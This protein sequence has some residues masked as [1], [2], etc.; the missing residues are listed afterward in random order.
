[1]LNT[2][3]CQQPICVPNMAAPFKT[4]FLVSNIR[5][6]NFSMAPRSEKLHDIS[7]VQRSQL[8]L[9]AQRFLCPSHVLHTPCPILWPT[10]M[11]HTVQATKNKW[12]NRTYISSDV[13]SLCDN[14]QCW[15]GWKQRSVVGQPI[16]SHHPHVWSGCSLAFIYCE[17]TSER[18]GFTD[19]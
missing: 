19:L 3:E 17:N 4:S 16:F 5:A 10:F 7:R 12:S 1:M 2:A 18:S 14:R 9:N 13:L 6:Q 15:V 8:Q 11:I